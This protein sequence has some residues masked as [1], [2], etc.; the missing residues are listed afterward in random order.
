MGPSLQQ[1][2]GLQNAR[3]KN[4]RLSESSTNGKQPFSLRIEANNSI[5]LFLIKSVGLS[6][7]IYP[8]SGN[9]NREASAY[10]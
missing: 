2:T 3:E 7:V 1:S 6:L 8:V 4:S 10:V 9:N 5:A